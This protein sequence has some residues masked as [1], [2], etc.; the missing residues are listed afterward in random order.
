MNQQNLLTAV[1]VLAI[2]AW[3]IYRQN[4]WRAYD[5]ARMWRMPLILGA[6]G[7]FIFLRTT[8]LT[9][10]STLDITLLVFEGALSLAIGATMGAMSRFGRDRQGGLLV[11]TGPA[12]SALWLVLI[13]VRVGIDIAA[14]GHGAAAVTSTGAILVLLG[15][16]RIGRIVVITRRSERLTGAEPL[17]PTAA[18]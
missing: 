2:L 9:D 11:R 8:Q 17:V 3:I 12:A 18:R 7:A 6:I 10:L 16:N 1:A 13:V 4:Q 15:V 5:P 14:V